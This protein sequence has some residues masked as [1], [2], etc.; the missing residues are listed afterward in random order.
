MPHAD[1]YIVSISR[2]RRVSILVRTHMSVTRD[3][4]TGFH[5]HRFVNLV[6][7]IYIVL[8]NTPE[9]AEH[10]VNQKEAHPQLRKE[11]NPAEHFFVS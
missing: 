3:S 6:T 9:P 10:F 7:D 5:C 1:I 11:G 8:Y 2:Q 4:D